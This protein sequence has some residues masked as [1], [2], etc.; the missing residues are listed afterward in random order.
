MFQLLFTTLLH[1]SLLTR[2]TIFHRNLIVIARTSTRSPS[3]YVRHQPLLSSI[4]NPGKPAAILA[5]LTPPSSPGQIV[6]LIAYPRN[7]DKP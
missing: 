3:P 1:R 7:S 2:A 5:R 4:L 6:Q